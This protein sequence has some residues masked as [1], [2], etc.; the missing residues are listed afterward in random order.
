[1]EDN[2]FDQNELSPSAKLGAIAGRLTYLAGRGDPYA[3]VLIEFSEALKEVYP[4]FDSFAF[5]MAGLMASIPQ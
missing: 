3:P 4:E 1:M 5:A 2:E